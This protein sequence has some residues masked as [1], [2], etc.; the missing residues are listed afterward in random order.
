MLACHSR[1]GDCSG[2]GG[3]GPAACTAWVITVWHDAQSPD[4]VTCSPKRGAEAGR[5]MHDADAALVGLEGAEDPAPVG[6]RLGGDLETCRER[7]LGAESVGLD[8]M[9]ERTGDAVG[10]ETGVRAVRVPDG[11][12]GEDRPRAPVLHRGHGGHRHMA[13]RAL[14]L[15]GGGRFR[16]VHDLAPHRRVE[17][18]VAGGVCHHR[19]APVEADR[20]IGAVL[21]GDPLVAGDAAVGGEEVVG[22]IGGRG[23]RLGPEAREVARQPQRCARVGPQRLRKP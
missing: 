15:D 3:P 21:G 7:G 22:G 5:R 4:E 14:A 23:R 13:A 20:D 10:C 17:V 6:R 19:R 16:M 1:N 11:E 8:L 18:G 2:K 9:A 12:V